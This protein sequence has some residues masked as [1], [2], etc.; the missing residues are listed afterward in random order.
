MITVRMAVGMR[1]VAS[2]GRVG[3]RGHQ[4]YSTQLA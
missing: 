4:F 3:M 1:R 2:V